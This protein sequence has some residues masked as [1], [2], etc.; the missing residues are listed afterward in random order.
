MKAF[1][2]DRQRAARPEGISWPTGRCLPNPEQPR[3]LDVLTAGA[4]AAGC[5]FAAPA[6][7]GMGPIA[8]VHSAEYLELFAQHPR[9]GGALP[10]AGAEVIPNI[11]PDRRERRRIRARP[12]ARRAITRPTPPAPSPRARGSPPTGRRRAR[13][14]AAAAVLEGERAAYA[15]SRPPGHHAFADLAGGFCFL[16]NSAIAADWL[17][18]AGQAGGDPRR[19]RASRQRHAG[20][21]L[22]AR[23]CAD[24]VAPRRSGAVLSV[25]LGPCAGTRRGRGAGGE[26]EPAARA[27]DGRRGLPARAR[28]ARW[29]GSRISEPRSWW[30]RWGWTRMR[31]TR[32]SGLAVTTPGF[33]RGSARRSRRPGCRSS[34][35]QEGGYLSDDLGANLTRFLEG[36]QAG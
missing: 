13:F 10:D 18:A 6:D 17:R 31:T 33:A 1:L 26:P 11:H 14:P 28:Q 36:V 3:R 7:R 32:C 27:W 12:W 20:H 16:N 23:R 2:D 8:A 21:L 30:S 22:R 4:E 19:R 15:L 29:S 34:L 24:R 5:V 9:A 35:V 25:L